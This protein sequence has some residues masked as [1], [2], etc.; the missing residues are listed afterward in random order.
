[1]LEG[2]GLPERAGAAAAV[3]VA[4]KVAITGTAATM[5]DAVTI[6]ASQDRCDRFGSTA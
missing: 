1:M 5:S 4:L 2:L 3:S 6:H